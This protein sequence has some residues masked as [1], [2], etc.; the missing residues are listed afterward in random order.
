VAHVAALLV[1]ALQPALWPWALGAVALNHLLLS[2][3]VLWPRG[4][5]LGPNLTRLPAAA[6]ERREV[7]LNFD[8]GPDPDVTPRVLELLDRHQ[9]KASF[10]CVGER[11]AAHP[12]IVR[13][14]ARRGHSVENHS[15]RHPNAFAFYG[16]RGL[17]REVDAAQ[18]VIARI[19]G[20]SPGFFRAPAGFRSPFLDPVL[21]GLGLRYVSW[22]RRGFDTVDGNAAAVLRR[23][24]RGLAAGDV[25]LLHDGGRA[26]TAAGEPV[27]LA[28]LPGLLERLSLAGLK[29]V[30]LPVACRGEPA[31]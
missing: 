31:V 16:P 10:F 18:S 7:S 27:I 13:E 8:D 2:C 3:A 12:E 30:P 4:R 24:T 20:R 25:L 5:V 19:T 11:A 17:R 15:H 29:S 6:V 22:T 9:A 1:F 26:R 28:V 21:A 23:L 14:I